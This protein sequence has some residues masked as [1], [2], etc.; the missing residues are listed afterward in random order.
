MGAALAVAECRDRSE[1]EGRILFGLP[2]GFPGS[3]V[4]TA[5]ATLDTAGSVWLWLL[6]VGVS[7]CPGGSSWGGKGGG[8]GEFERR[9]VWWRWLRSRG[10]LCVRITAFWAGAVRRRVAIAVLTT[11]RA[12]ASSTGPRERRANTSFRLSIVCC[13]CDTTPDAAQV[14][15]EPIDMPDPRPPSLELVAAAAAEWAGSWCG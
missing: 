5:A 9:V 2:A 7:S 11:A 8:D 1:G 12:R 13:P 10:L 15:P 4:S 14:P 3:F 6:E